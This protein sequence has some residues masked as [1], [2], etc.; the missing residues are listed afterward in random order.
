MAKVGEGDA[1]WIVEDREDGANV[2]NWH[3]AERN[4][5]SWASA[6]LRELLQGVVLPVGEV[7]PSAPHDVR[8]STSSS[9][10]NNR[11]STYARVVV[12]KVDKI[13][14]DAMLYNRKGKLKTL[15][16]LKVE[17]KWKL[18]PSTG[19][20]QSEDSKDAVSGLL[21]FELYDT[22]PDVNWTCSSQG[23]QAERAKQVLRTLGVREV[24]HVAKRF[25]DELAEGGD[26]DISSFQR[27]PSQLASNAP[28][29]GSLGAPEMKT[30]TAPPPEKKSASSAPATTSKATL[31][32]KT[33][34][35]KASLEIDEFFRCSPMDLFLALTD[36]R[37]VSAYT[38]AKTSIKAEEGGAFSIKSGRYSGTFEE[39]KPGQRIIMKW[40]LDK[41]PANLFTRVEIDI[42]QNEGHSELRL[43]H[44]GVPA[45]FVHETETEWRVE[46]FER[47][48]M[49]LG[50]GQPR[51]F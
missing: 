24:Q 43:R 8:S 42:K 19:A 4:V 1:R 31:P 20:E 48:R 21:K 12:Y 37:R 32:H 30:S 41:Y 11:S 16:D 36:E 13:E 47:L 17:A 27:K 39:C 38:M 15:A 40:R 46:I 51:V 9:Q 10:N 7:D 35:K 28:L 23:A 6:R 26:V 3:W 2:N 45:E 25:M 34:A 33:A 14:G 5:F 29:T 22:E 50:Y 18:V 44:F 49:V